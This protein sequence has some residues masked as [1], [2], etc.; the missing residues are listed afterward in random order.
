MPMDGLTIGRM[1]TEL[2]AALIGGRIDKV[3]QPEKDLVILTIRAG[4][5]N[6]K[7]LLCA[8]PVHARL[9]LTAESFTSPL[10]PSMFCMLLRKVLLGGRVMDFQ[11]PGGDRAVHLLVETRDELG[12]QVE[13]RLVLEIMSRHSNLVL[14]DGEG[15]ILDAARHVDG[16]MSRVRQVLPGRIYEAPPDQGRLDPAAMDAASLRERLQSMGDT[17]LWKG[18]AQAITGLSHL[19]AQEIAYRL[20]P[21]GSGASDEPA[22]DAARLLDWWQRLDAMHDPRV[23]LDETGAA[24]D[25][26]AFPYVSLSLE[27]QQPYP[28]LSH[29]MEAFFGQRDYTERIKQKSATMTKLLKTHI[30]RCERKLAQQEEVLLDARRMEDY[31]KMGELIQAS[32]WMLEKGQTKATLTDYYDPNGGEVTVSLDP[33][34]S[35]VENAQKYF[36]KYRKA[37]SA[38]EMA[39]EQKRLTLTELSYLESAYL[40][41]GMATTESELEEVRQDLVQHG[42]M[43][44][45]S[46]RKQMRQLPPSKPAVYRSTN[47]FDILVG[48]NA[49][50]NDRLTAAAQPDDVWF[51]AK[52]MPGSHVILRTEGKS[53]MEEDLLDA[54]Q[55]AAW[56]SKGQRSS[57]VPIDYTQRRYVKKPA[58]AKAGRV[59]YTHQRTLFVTPVQ[60]LMDALRKKPASD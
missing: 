23:L 47:G 5:A 38:R 40:D 2:K 52:D 14:L 35:P 24:A 3:T 26:L 18:L 48:K 60:Q 13:R 27:R 8:S 56:Y 11:Q 4:G 32:L 6:H 54:A 10:E 49:A 29:A 33:L 28:T 46:N 15:K 39:T 55:V 59:H 34:L 12:D 1:V 36:K 37:R 30:D 7:L 20:H 57:T 44:R 31:R 16:A 25:V 19:T 21:G 45:N 22:A 42:Y 53:P 9:H 51:H 43:K 50:Q 41:L 58:G 17:P